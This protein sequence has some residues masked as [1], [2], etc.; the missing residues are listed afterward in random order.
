MDLMFSGILRNN[1]LV[2]K[3]DFFLVINKKNTDVIG[4]YPINKQ[5]IGSTA[6]LTGIID[7]ASRDYGLLH[8]Q[9]FYINTYSMNVSVGNIPTVNQSYVGD[10]I[11]FYS[12][13]SGITYTTLNNKSGHQ[14][15]SNE[16]III[17]RAFDQYDSNLSGEN[18]FLPGEI[19][20]TISSDN[21]TGVRFFAEDVEAF[22]YKIDFNRFKLTSLNYKFPISRPISFPV[23]VDISAS[24]NAKSILT[25]SFF[26]TLDKTQNYNLILDINS[27]GQGVS[28]SKI[29]FSGCNFNSISYDSSIRTKNSAELNFR[30][31]INPDDV[32][33][34]I[35]SSGNILYC[36]LEGSKKMLIF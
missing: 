30:L 13:G 6:Q 9:N 22:S 36:S 1:D 17:P 12:S 24:L 21:P 27:N 3:K 4:N 18:I 31:N 26:D 29:L 23:A 28:P 15:N 20:L 35:F 14:E 5:S 8:F 32:N 19:A 16:R 10:N 34:A 2:D 33:K 11:I 7:P 25:G